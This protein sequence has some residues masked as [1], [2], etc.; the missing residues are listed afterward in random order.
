MGRHKGAVLGL[1]MSCGW[2]AEGLSADFIYGKYREWTADLSAEAQF[3]LF[4][5]TAQRCYRIA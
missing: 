1:V 2:V 3:A 4:T 5:G